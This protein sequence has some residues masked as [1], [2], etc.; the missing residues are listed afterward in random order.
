MKYLKG[1][2]FL[3]A[4]A[5]V[6]VLFFGVF[7]YLPS[8]FLVLGVLK[9]VNWLIIDVNFAALGIKLLLHGSAFILM[10]L[11]FAI[12]ALNSVLNGDVNI[13]R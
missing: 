11:F 13:K 12:T 5:V 9:L 3:A 6:L 8:Y 1:L 2:L 4:L 10:F 7:F